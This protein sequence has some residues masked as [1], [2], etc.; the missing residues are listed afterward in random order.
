MAVAI[1]GSTSQEVPKCL[2]FADDILLT[3]PTGDKMCQLIDT[4]FFWYQDNEMTI[5]VPKS[6][7]TPKGTPFSIN[8]E[9][10]PQV[11]S[12]RYL[13]I[14]LGNNGT[15]PTS[16]IEENICQA[17]GALNCIKTLW[18]TEYGPQPLR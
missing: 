16:L 5:N 1:N 17:T 8:G 10:L 2:L 9:E 11:D 14:P 12:Y 13:G 7:T 18:Q 4:I 15:N 6:G 3:S